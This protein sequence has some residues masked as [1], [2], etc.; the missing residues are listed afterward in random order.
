MPHQ[1]SLIADRAHIDA[2][3]TPVV[4]PMRS[5]IHRGERVGG[6][7]ALES[8]EETRSHVANIGR[9]LW[10]CGVG[11]TRRSDSTGSVRVAVDAQER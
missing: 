11:G 9:Q 3:V 10:T 5:A 6:V 8:A 7:V 1:C 4:Q 2:E